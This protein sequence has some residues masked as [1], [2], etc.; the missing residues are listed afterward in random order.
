M[1]ERLFVVVI[2]EQEDEHATIRL[3]TAEEVLA[4][5]DHHS[6][7]AVIQGRVVKGFGQPLDPKRV[8]RSAK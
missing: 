6:G 3:M 8:K 7:F 5:P 4:I 2:H 1:S